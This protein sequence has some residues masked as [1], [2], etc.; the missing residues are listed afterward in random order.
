MS[1]PKMPVLADGGD[2]CI[3]GTAAEKNHAHGATPVKL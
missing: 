1:L 2:H 3:P